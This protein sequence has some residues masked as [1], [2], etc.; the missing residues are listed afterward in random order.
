MPVLV[1]F[2]APWCGLCRIVEPMLQQFHATSAPALKLV[3]INADE[4][5]SLARLYQLKSIPALF[6]FVQGELVYRQD[7]L[8]DRH[9]I[10]AS[11]AELV[12]CLG[13]VAR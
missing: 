12:N 10:Q 13:L 6:L 2:W 1:S 8:G 11:L 9:H 3:K 7:L 5:L 4:N